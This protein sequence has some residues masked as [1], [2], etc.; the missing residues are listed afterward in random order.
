MFYSRTAKRATEAAPA[1]SKEEAVYNIELDKN[2]HKILK[3]TGET[4]IYDIIQASLEDSKI[5]NIIRRA[6]QGDA[7]V[8]EIMAGQYMDTSMLPSTLAEAQNF[9]IAAKREFDRLPIETRRLFNMSAEEYVSSYGTQKWMD[10][11]GITE[12]IRREEERKKAEKEAE[13]AWKK[14]KAAEKKEKEVSE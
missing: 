5:E 14:M 1:G 11:M 12:K 6:T 10:N 3:K 8:L 4:N 2:G 7:G 13:K 9:V